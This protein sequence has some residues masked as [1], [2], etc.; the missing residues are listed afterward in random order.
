MIIHLE[1]KIIAMYLTLLDLRIL[2][3]HHN[4]LVISAIRTHKSELI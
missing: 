3:N 4:Q 1:A 2:N